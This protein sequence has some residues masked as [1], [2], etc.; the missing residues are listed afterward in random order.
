MGTLA[1]QEG[2]LDGLLCLLQMLFVEAQEGRPAE[3][4]RLVVPLRKLSQEQEGPAERQQLRQALHRALLDDHGALI[5][6][7]LLE[8]RADIDGMH[9]DFPGASFVSPLWLASCHGSSAATRGLVQAKA[10]VNNG[11]PTCGGQQTPVFV[12]AQHGHCEVVRVLT[13]ANA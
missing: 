7:A 11:R 13:D 12:A 4:N 5:V 10:C 3:L 2:R 9:L 6:R 8:A 1:A